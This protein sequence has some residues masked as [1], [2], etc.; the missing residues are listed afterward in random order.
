MKREQRKEK[1]RFYKTRV[2]KLTMCMVDVITAIIINFM[3]QN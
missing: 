3:P 2:S 1:E